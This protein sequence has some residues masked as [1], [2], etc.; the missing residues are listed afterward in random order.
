[1]D[2]ACF[3]SREGRDSRHHSNSSTGSRER[4]STHPFQKPVLQITPEKVSQNTVANGAAAVNFTHLPFWHA[5][6]LRNRIFP[7]HR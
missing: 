1:M 6:L 5:A 7:Q 3:N 4:Q 2:V